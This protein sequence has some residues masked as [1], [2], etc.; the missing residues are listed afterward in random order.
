LEKRNKAPKD[1][2]YQKVRIILL[3][4]REGQGPSSKVRTT[5]GQGR[6]SKFR[7]GEEGGQGNA[8]RRPNEWR[9][10]A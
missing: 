2:C 5:R 3:K 6:K 10:S 4:K 1:S 9:K 8:R 7:R